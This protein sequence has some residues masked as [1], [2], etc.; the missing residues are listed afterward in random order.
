VNTYIFRPFLSDWV[1][2]VSNTTTGL[3][4]QMESHSLS[5]EG[6][7]IRPPVPTDSVSAGEYFETLYIINCSFAVIHQP[8]SL[9]ERFAVM[10]PGS[11]DDI[12]AG[13]DYLNAVHYIKNST[14][15]K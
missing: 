12:S 13:R 15:G 3:V 11:T 10:Y 7:A 1:T 6:I 8:P 9:A 14:S 4:V 2:N 5:S